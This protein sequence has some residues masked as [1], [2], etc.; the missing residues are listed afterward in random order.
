[1]PS[2]RAEHG[3]TRLSTHKFSDSEKLTNSEFELNSVIEIG[4]RS[5][6]NEQAGDCFAEEQSSAGN[7]AEFLQSAVLQISN[8]HISREFDWR[9]FQ[10]PYRKK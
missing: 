2:A 9:E 10:N 4:S 8:L 6:Q 1:M 3:G 7:S 5:M